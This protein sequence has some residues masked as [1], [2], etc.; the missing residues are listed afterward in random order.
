MINMIKILRKYFTFNQ[1]NG[2]QPIQSKRFVVGIF[3]LIMIFNSGLQFLNCYLLKQ[4]SLTANLNT[5]NIITEINKIR[6]NYGLA[7]LTENP[8]LDIAALLKAQD[9]IENDYFNHYSPEGKTPWDWISSVKYN[10]KY[11]GENL[12]LNFFN[13]QETV[14]AWLDSPSHKENILNPNY[15]DTGVAILSGVTSTTKEQRTVVVQMFGTE[16]SNVVK[17]MPVKSIDTKVITSTIPSTTTTKLITTTTIAT[18]TTTIMKIVNAIDNS[19]DKR[20]DIK[21]NEV[22]LLKNI[23]PVLNQQSEQ[24]NK[25][26]SLSLQI[27]NDVVSHKTVKTI[28]NS[29]GI[30][31]LFLGIFGIINISSEN[32][33][34]NMFR[35]KLLI[36]NSLVLIIGLGFLLNNITIFI[37]KIRIP[38]I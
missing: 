32:T 25:T 10:Y 37:Y 16:K 20:K 35:K 12:A 36:R 24:N 38:T 15:K 17:S 31:L 14:Q 2:Y 3:V 13:D 8:K 23:A 11:A 6:T 30:G 33:I 7:P 19:N 9:M 18:T 4:N 5:L 21:E 28:N 29:F 34:S 26:A 27:V 22:T 1:E